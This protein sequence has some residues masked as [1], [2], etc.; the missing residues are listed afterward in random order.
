MSIVRRYFDL[1]ITEITKDKALR[2]YGVFVAAG[3]VLTFWSWHVSG[4]VNLLSNEVEP[5]C[6]PFFENCFRYRILS[7]DEVKLLLFLFGFVSAIG[8]LLFLSKRLCGAAYWWLILLNVFK[9][10]IYIQDYRLR[11]N[12]HYMLYFVTFVFLFLPGKRR[13][14]RYT[15]VLFYVWAS[16]LKLNVEWLSGSALYA[17]PLWIPDAL[18]PASC[19]Y[20]VT[21]EAVIVWGILSA[22]KWVYWSTFFQLCLFH[23]VS[24]PVVGFFYPMLMF[25]LL[26][27]FP[28]TY[29]IS[30][31]REPKSLFAPLIRG[32][33]PRMT[34]VF[35][36]FFSF[37]Q[38]IPFLM[39][40]DSK[41]TGEGR[42]FSLH[43][44]DALVVCDGAITLK[45]KDGTKQE[46]PIPTKEVPRIKC[47][48]I[49]NF[50]R[51]K[52]LCAE[53][54][55]NPVFADLD[56]SYRARR[57]HEETMRLLV[58]VKDFCSQNLSYDLFR[59]N[60]W[61]LKD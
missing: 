7:Y 19:I 37:L 39:P 22:R 59:P 60:D 1:Q 20:A 31:P 54:E 27:I 36:A 4:V 21:L 8:V 26:A 42:L 24:W 58:D 9:T 38:L 47:D 6:W 17:K 48:P 11:L 49:V 14:L 53:F 18:I 16:V 32:K 33:E 25:A 29:F 61:I 41:V 28:L 52:R 56:L 12:Q 15:L 5:L 34:Y 50:S 46:L 23:L 35:I 51:A 45:F 13:L 55:D 30:E 2:L 10:L 44:F 3:Q 57:G 40:G 43:M